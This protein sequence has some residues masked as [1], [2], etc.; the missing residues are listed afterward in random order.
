MIQY[1]PT[2]DKVVERPILMFPPFINKFYLM[3]LQPENSFVGYVVEQGFTVFL[4]SWRSATEEQARITWEDYLEMGP[5]T[6][7]R[8]VREITRRRQAQRPRL[9]HRRSDDLLGAGVAQGSWRRSGGKPDPD[10]VAARLFRA[11]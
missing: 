9:L 2:T 5:L 3:D 7:L 8:V 6:A 4:V 10:D 11:R 1:T